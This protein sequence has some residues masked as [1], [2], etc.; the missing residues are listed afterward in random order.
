LKLKENSHPYA[1]ITI[2]LWALAYVLT[3][4]ALSYF[5]PFSLGFLRYAV[6]SAALL[7]VVFWKRLHVPRLR[8]LPLFALAGAT[9]FFIYMIVFNLGQQ[10]VTAATGSVV[11]ST[12]PVI[13]AV[14]ARIFFG[15]KIRAVQWTAIAIE[16]VGVLVLVLLDGEFSA[17]GAL[18][19]LIL[20]ALNISV[21]NLL[22]RL[23][24]K[25]YSALHATSYSIFFGT[26]MLAV[27]LPQSVAEVSAAPP[28]GIFYAVFMG[29]FSSAIAY[30]AW[31][32]AFACAKNT[33]H[34]SNYMFLTPFLTS[35]LGFF[36]LGET[37]DAAT[38]IGGAIILLGV[39][40]FNFGSRSPKQG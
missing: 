19:L 15:E 26:L 22:Q 33:S 39:F 10:H 3:R 35:L 16:F 23:L 34:V 8:E 38:V 27:F 5:S 20:A 9:G 11:I 12:A 25:K 13:T 28:I 1:I 37:P 36:I 40:I 17:N 30:I 29:I 32:K 21:Y 2:I 7:G 6:A 31:A 18:L 24:T 4:A 14:L